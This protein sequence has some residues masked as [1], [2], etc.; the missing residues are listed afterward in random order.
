MAHLQRVCKRCPI[1]RIES[2][3]PVRVTSGRCSSA[4][5]RVPEHLL[6]VMERPA[7]LDSRE[8]A[9]CRKSWKWRPVIFSALAGGRPGLLGVMPLCPHGIARDGSTSGSCSLP[10]GSWADH[11]NQR[12]P[13]AARDRQRA[14]VAVLGLLGPDSQ[15]VPLEVAFGPLQAQQL[16]AAAAR[17]EGRNTQPLQPGRTR[18][19]EPPLLAGRPDLALSRQL[20]RNRAAGRVWR[21][22]HAS[23]W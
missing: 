9:S 15:L 5:V 22:S 6:H 13:A 18:R 12:P 23:G 17:F 7:G 1:F 14:R 16:A 3:S 19:Q 10:A 8:P 2:C 11:L 4:Q 20:V 21:A